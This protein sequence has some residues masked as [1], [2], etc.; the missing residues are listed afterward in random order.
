M[1]ANGFSSRCLRAGA[2]DPLVGGIHQ[3]VEAAEPLDRHDL[4]LAKGGHRGQAAPGHAPPSR[5]AVRPPQGELRPA[6]RAGVRLRV[7]AAVRRIVVLRLAVGAHREAPHG[8]GRAVVG[9]GRD[10]A[11]A[12]TAVGAVGERVAVAAVARLEDVGDACRAGGEVGHDQRAR[13]AAFALANGEACPSRR[14]EEGRLQALD[15]G[16]GGLVDFEAPQ[17]VAQHRLGPL[18]LDDHTGGR[19]VDPAGKIELL[20]QAKDERPEPDA[21]HGAARREVACVRSWLHPPR[22]ET[23]AGG[24]AAVLDA[25]STDAGHSLSKIGQKGRFSRE[26]GASTSSFTCRRALSPRSNPMGR[27]LGCPDRFL[28]MMPPSRYAA[29]PLGVTG[30]SGRSEII[31]FEP[32]LGHSSV[33][34][35][36]EHGCRARELEGAAGTDGTS[37]RAP[38]PDP[39]RRSRSG[40]LRVM[41]VV[42][43]TAPGVALAGAID[44]ASTP[45]ASGAIQGIIV[46]DVTGQPLADCNVVIEGISVGTTSDAHGIFR[47]PPVPSPAAVIIVSRIGYEM[48]RVTP[49]PD[50]SL[51][52]L[53]IRL[54]PAVLRSPE[55]TVT[56]TR[57]KERETPA[58]FSDLSRGEIQARY[59]AEDVPV[60]LASYPRPPT[61]R[62]AATASVTRTSPS[63]A[64]T[65]A[66]SRC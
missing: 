16:D 31:P 57:A 9:D 13:L 26:T 43:S 59:H 38:P 61:I 41:P 21:L 30:A 56:A 2:Q 28:R 62:I 35:R 53:S 11:V 4:A 46:D 54:R 29:A 51:S 23:G 27:N 32:E 5:R 65:S 24:R 3:Q 52:S 33:G 1:S 40:S 39:P 14:V 12:G 7:E 66:G 64:S 60:L 17:E 48:R 15:D 22:P 34:K 36:G 50:R 8:G 19:V 20:R 25:A 18:R 37:L 58:A 49:D 55:I 10:D 45:D 47:L 63:A 44:P 42:I 6:D